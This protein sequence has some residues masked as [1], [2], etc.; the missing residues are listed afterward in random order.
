M[1]EASAASAR[2]EPLPGPRRVLIVA[3]EASGDRYG[4]GLMRALSARLPHITFTGI[5]GA[6]MRDAGLESLM[7]AE[8]IAVLGFVEVV[9]SLPVIRQAFSLCM[10]QIE[11]GVD[12]VLPVDYPGFNLRLARRAKQAGVP[13][14]YFVSPQVWAWRPGRVAAI[15]ETV[16]RMLVIFPFEEEFYRERGVDALFV[17]HPLVDLM[18]RERPRCAREDTARAL[19]LDPSRRVVGL[20]PGSRVKEVRRNLPPML[21]AA[22]LLTERF[23]GLQFVIPIASTLPRPVLQAMV[24]L[25]EAV[26]AEGS[27]YETLAVCEA[28]A[29]SSGTATVETGLMEVPMV[30]VYRLHPV[31]YHLARH[32]TDLS[33]FGMV[34]LVAGR[35]IVPE[36]IQADYTAERLAGE[37]GRFLADP[38]EATRTRRDLRAMRERLGGPGAFERA[39]DAIAQVL[40]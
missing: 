33:T 16:R 21:A 3:G 12:L 4:A 18:A 39:A 7:D 11:R 15:A 23:E 37:L 8:R 10:E 20:L 27:Y 32:M 40:A 29:V 1:P 17:G 35:R 9:G 31:T 22:R 14:V 13:V 5:G 28:A 19:G 25:P 26:L 38:A 2:P 6:C 36:L 34:N 24:D 30:V